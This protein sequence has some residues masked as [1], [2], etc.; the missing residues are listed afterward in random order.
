M[1][2]SPVVERW[3]EARHSLAA[4]ALRSA[5]HCSALH[6]GFHVVLP[7]MRKW[8]LSC[9]IGLLDSMATTCQSMRTAKNVLECTGLMQHPRIARALESTGVRALNRDCRPVVVE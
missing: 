6:L 8:L 4:R 7:C 3:I 9:D 1:K 5:P 2:F